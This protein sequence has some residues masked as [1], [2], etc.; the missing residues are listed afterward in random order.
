LIF[1]TAPASNVVLTLYVDDVAIWTITVTWGSTT[2][3]STTFTGWPYAEWSLLT[4][5]FTTLTD[6]NLE[7]ELIIQ[8]EDI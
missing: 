7:W 6:I 2:G 8:S 1:K 4:Y 3:T 5:E